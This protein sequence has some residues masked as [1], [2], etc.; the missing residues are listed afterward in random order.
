MA[1]LVFEKI[2][3]F[4]SCSFFLRENVSR[5]VVIIAQPRHY[6]FRL[7]FYPTVTDRLVS[8]FITCNFSRM[9]A[10]VRF[11]RQGAFIATDI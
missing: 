8:F 7:N 5:A 1:L 2:Q 9:M 4:E 11:G 10:T 3:K 6:L